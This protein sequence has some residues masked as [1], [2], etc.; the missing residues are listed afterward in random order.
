MRLIQTVTVGAGGGG[1]AFTNIPQG[2]DDL[3]V[4][5]SARGSYAG[6]TTH[7]GLYINGSGYPD[8]SSNANKTMLGN[9]STATSS[10]FGVT[11]WTF[12][13]S[14]PAATATANTFGNMSIYIANY[15]KGPTTKIITSDAVSE[16]NATAGLLELSATQ[17]I[18]SNPITALNFD[19]AVQYST[20]SLYGIT[21]GSGGATVA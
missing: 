10:P 14:I 4:L 6:A 18:N 3:L 1:I 12:I 13:G 7:Y 21:R 2:Y 11:G 16:N 5:L 8:S 19:A 9:G 20:A 17:R 15:S